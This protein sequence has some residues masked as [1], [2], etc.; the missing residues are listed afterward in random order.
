[1]VEAEN[2]TPME[3]PEDTSLP[4]R[5]ESKNATSAAPPTTQVV[6]QRRVVVKTKEGLVPVEEVKS[7]T[8]KAIAADAPLVKM[9]SSN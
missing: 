3:T 6:E 9:I 2:P 8:S 5:T 7:V 1:M 4:Q